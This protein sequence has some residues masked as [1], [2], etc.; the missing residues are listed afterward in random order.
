MDL[1]D[2]TGDRLVHS[3]VALLASNIAG[4]V[5]GVGFWAFAAHL[6]SAKDVGYGAA[7]ITA[8]TLLA[9]VA[10]LNLSW[11]FP[12]FLFGAGARAG[13]V[14]R[15][16]YS[17]SVL[18]AVAVSIVFLTLTGHHSY[19]EAGFLPALYFVVAVV[20]WD[21]FTIEDAA[22]VGLRATFWVPVENTSFS[23]LKIVLLPVMSLAAPVVGVFLSWT[24]PVILCI[25]PIN[26]YLF[27]RVLP[28]HVAWAK[29]RVSIPDRRVVSSILLGEYAGGLAQIA[30][31]SLPGLM[32]VSRLGGA[33]EAY[34]QTPWIIGFSFDLLLFSVASALL[35]ETSARPSVAPQSVRRSLRLALGLLVPG[36]VVLV[37]GAH[38]LLSIL[39]ASY[40]QHGTRLLQYLALTLPFMGVNV[41]YIT[42][43]RMARRVRRVVLV[44]VYLSAVVLALT[45]LLIGPEGIA[46]AG[47]AFLIGQASLSCAVGPSVVRQYRHAEMAPAFAPGATLVAQASS[48]G[49]GRAPD[50]P[51]ADDAMPRG[52]GASSASGD[53]G[54]PGVLWATVRAHG[55]RAAAAAW[56]TVT[57]FAAARR[58]ARGAPRPRDARSIVAAGLLVVDAAALVLTAAGVGGPVRVVVGLAFALLVPGWAVVGLFGFKEAALE[59]SLTVA[60]S[61]AMLVIVAQLMLTFGAW[62]LAALEVVLCI[63]CAPSLVWQAWAVVSRGAP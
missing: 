25:V 29:G 41:L 11:I 21:I 62:D 30:M 51:L 36:V 23:A 33:Q 14:L 19:I 34:F 5:L 13:T 57:G 37:V 35:V 20:L 31:V 49:A 3:T 24:L 2:A 1:P 63:L 16:G 18:V 40:A 48:G 10:Q 7:E 28:A 61:L 44:Q 47:L 54:H 59:L 45:A 58:A 55:V 39:G 43:A 50:D 56:S 26:W 22:L 38:L 6:F 8:M 17:V 53:G 15:A 9:S 46:G 52:V 60:A 42:Y 4:G 32:I 27:T 12:R